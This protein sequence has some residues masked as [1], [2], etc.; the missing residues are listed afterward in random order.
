MKY[1]KV[2]TKREIGTGD[3]K[4]TYW[5]SAGYIKQTDKGTHYLT[6][7]SQPNTEFFIFEDEEESLPEIQL[8]R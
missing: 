8:E 7:F 3:E 2:L 6:L 4:K 5:F 1:L